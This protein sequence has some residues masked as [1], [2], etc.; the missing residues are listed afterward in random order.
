MKEVLKP[1]LKRGSGFLQVLVLSSGDVRDADSA[2]ARSVSP[3]PL[4]ESPLFPAAHA[5]RDVLPLTLFA[6]KQIDAGR[7][8]HI[9]TV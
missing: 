5:L 7:V 2:P 8:A 3:R 4:R 9:S 1:L 6:E